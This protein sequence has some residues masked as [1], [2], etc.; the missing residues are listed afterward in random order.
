MGIENITARIL[1]EA[2]DEA[3]KTQEAAAAQKAAMLEKAAQDAAAA[4]AKMAEKATEDAKVLLERR[5]SVA[6]LEARKLRLAAK[7]GGTGG[8][9]PGGCREDR[10]TGR[11][12]LSRFH[13]KD[14]GAVQGGRRRDLPERE[15]F[16]Q[17]ERQPGEGT[18]RFQADG[19]RRTG[20]HRRRIHP[21][22]GKSICECFAGKNSGDREEEDD[23]RGSRN[24]VWLIPKKEESLWEQ[25]L[26]LPARESA[27]RNAIFLEER[28]L[29]S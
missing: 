16:R 9:F 6:E 26:Y 7:P 11:Q 24:S 14:T 8:D 22:T 21:E 25:I 4:E 18:G 3:K 5:N 12:C 19:R 1:Q 15:R 17:S 28:S 10:I 29:E 2:K 13:R 27:A 20:E 23:R